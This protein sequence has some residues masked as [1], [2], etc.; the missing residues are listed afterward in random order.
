M[1]NSG[2]RKLLWGGDIVES[3]YRSLSDISVLSLEKGE[4]NLGDVIKGKMT[5]VVNTGSEHA[6]FLAQIG[7][8]NSLKAQNAEK[9]E[10]VAFPSNQF[11]NEPADFATTKAKYAS[12][13]SFPVLQKLEVNGAFTHPVFKYLKRHSSLYN[14]TLLN[15][16][17]ITDDFCK[18]LCDAKGEVV[19]FYPSSVPIA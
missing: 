14:L 7:A 17:R 2:F 10:V 12:V 11:H 4:M 8:L 1:G 9:L 19:A 18:F 3:P 6:G 15:G 13:A 16:E 5:I